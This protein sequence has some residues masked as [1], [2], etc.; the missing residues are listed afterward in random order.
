MRA[1]IIAFSL[2]GLLAPTVA[3]AE[4]TEIIVRV[5]A[6]DSKFVGT[7]MGGMRIIRR[8]A[9]TG[10]I[11]AT[12]LTQGGTGNTKLIMMRTKAVGRNWPT[13]QLPN[14]SP[15]LIS[16]SRASSRLKLTGLRDSPRRRFACFQPSGSFLAEG[17]PAGMA[18]CSTSPV[19][20]SMCAASA[21]QTSDRSG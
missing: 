4:Q 11:L 14:S 7:S 9:H 13:A 10:E 17:S 2:A 21:Y 19:S 20:S 16:M 15:R 3:S 8:D 1:F 12:G 5:L 6:K 18:G